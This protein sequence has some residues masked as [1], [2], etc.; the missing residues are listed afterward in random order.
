MLVTPTFT[1][2]SSDP[3]GKLSP[4]SLIL[5]DMVALSDP[6][7]FASEPTIEAFYNFSELEADTNP[8]PAENLP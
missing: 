2:I 7:M 3:T 8:P 1:M 5:E 4:I 6:A